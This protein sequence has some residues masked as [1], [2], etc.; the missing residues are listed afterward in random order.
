MTIRKNIIR[1]IIVFIIVILFFSLNIEAEGQYPVLRRGDK[2]NKVKYMQ[3]RL[4]K[5]GFLAGKADG[6][7]GL[8]T[9][10]AVELLQQFYGLKSDGVVGTRTWKIL[11]KEEK[12]NRTY[13]VKKGDTL[14]DLSRK[15]SIPLQKIKEINDKNDG[16]FIITGEKLKIPG[17]VRP[18][19][20]EIIHWNTVNN[21]L[22]IGERIILTDIESGLNFRVKRRGG[23]NHADV[24]P[25]TC[26]DT[27]VFLQLYGGD[28]S[29]ERRALIAH[30]NGRQIAAS[31]NGQPHG[32][33]SIMDNNFP[34][35]ICLHFKGSKLHKEEKQ[36][37][38]HQKMVEKAGK[39]S[40]PLG[41]IH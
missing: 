27:Q 20:I 41:N 18:K 34:G 36:D 35:H 4:R 13:S 32:N 22:K 14:W 38:E 26:K 31:I 6:L 28:W 30:I 21:L 24:E 7:F 25:L 33:Y 40:W 37:N 5:K 15:F 17:E 29:W 19:N 1:I 12:I 39:Y 10:L 9:E 11:H 3:E 23:S 8:Q 16:D 2:G